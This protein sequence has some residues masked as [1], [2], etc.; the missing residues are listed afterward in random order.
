MHCVW[1]MYDKITALEPNKTVG[2]NWIV[3]LKG[4]VDSIG[5]KQSWHKRPFMVD[6]R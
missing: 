1:F 2:I 5:S 3:V 4:L 6:L